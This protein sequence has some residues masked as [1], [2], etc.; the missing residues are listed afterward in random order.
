MIHLNIL[1][2]MAIPTDLKQKQEQQFPEHTYN[3]I[4]DI[5]LYENLAE[6]DCIVSYGS[7]I[8]EAVLEKA[9]G[10]HWL[11]V[12]SAGVEE[13]PHAKLQEKNIIVTNVRGIHAIPMAE[14]TMA[15][16]LSHVKK[17]SDFASNQ[18]K[19]NWDRSIETVELAEQTVVVIGTGAIGSQISYLAQVFQMNVI[20]VNTSG[21]PSKAFDKAIAIENLKDILPDADFVVSVLPET[22]GTINLYQRAQF[23]A[24]KKTAAFI[25]IG[26]GSAVSEEV[27][28]EVAKQ[29]LIDHLYLDVTPI[30]PL[31]R[32]H[33]LWT[34]PNITITPH[35]SALSSKYLYRS[36]DIWLEN[37]EKFQKKEPLLNTINLKRGY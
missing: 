2:T 29:Q 3:Y 20:G 30:E 19:S 33:A 22:K 13:L 6:I 31:P 34:F 23:E 35:V 16:M 18:A 1:F 11:M 15:Y 26:R 24:M 32:D 5:A 7:D 36:F 17:L 14:F 4:E 9:K 12:F 8:T 27:L 10:L 21:K 28:Q 37:M 25:N